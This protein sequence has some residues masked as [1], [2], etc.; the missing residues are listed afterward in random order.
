MDSANGNW[1]KRLYVHRAME[2]KQPHAIT[3]PL[4]R[5]DRVKATYRGWKPYLMHMEK[6]AGTRGCPPEQPFSHA[7]GGKRTARKDSAERIAPSF[8][9]IEKGLDEKTFERLA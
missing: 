7:Y 5:R 4:K 9:R 8:T 1:R 6:V 2:M 3:E